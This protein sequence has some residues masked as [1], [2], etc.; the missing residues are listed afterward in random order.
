[1]NY[2]D[3]CIYSNLVKSEKS[4]I[5]LKPYIQSEVEAMCRLIELTDAADY[6]MSPQ[7]KKEFENDSNQELREKKLEI[8]GWFGQ[9]SKSSTRLNLIPVMNTDG[10]TPMLPISDPYDPPR[11]PGA[12]SYAPARPNNSGP[13]QVGFNIFFQ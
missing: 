7:A 6:V 12:P 2:L 1:M 3:T 4:E 10:M 8:Y 13:Y 9:V 5:A 11:P